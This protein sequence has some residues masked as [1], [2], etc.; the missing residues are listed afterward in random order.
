MVRRMSP[1]ERRRRGN[2][3]RGGAGHRLDEGNAY[4]EQ[5]GSGHLAVPGR[6]PDAEPG[7]H[8]LSKQGRDREQTEAGRGVCGPALEF[9]QQREGLRRKA[10]VRTGLGKSDRPG[11]QGGLRKRGLWESD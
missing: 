6:C 2:A 9:R 3:L 11:S 10:K 8:Q 4:A 7:E 1:Y 5:R